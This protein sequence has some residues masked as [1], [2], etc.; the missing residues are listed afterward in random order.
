MRYASNPENL[1]QIAK[2]LGVA[3]IVEGSVQKVGDSVRINVQLVEA[4]TDTHLWAEIYDR[5]LVDVFGIQ[6]EVATAIAQ[7]LQAK[8]TVDEQQQVQARP[9]SNAAA[10]DAYL[11]GL[12]VES[13][14]NF[15][16][17][18]NER[19][20]AFYREATRLDP[21]FVE[22][23]AHQASVQSFLYSNSVGH[24]P[25]TLA[26]LKAAAETTARLRPD[27]GEAWLTEGYYRY[28]GLRD[29][30]GAAKAFE[31]AAAKMP[32]NADVFGVLGSV[33]RRLGQMPAAI[34]HLQRAAELDPGNAGWLGTLG[35][36][37]T[38]LRRYD[39]ARVVIDRALAI[40][41]EDADF[42][43]YKIWSYQAQGNLD[44]A[45][46]L[47]TALPAP[48]DGDDPTL[49]SRLV[50]AWYQRQFDGALSLCDVMLAKAARGAA[51][52]KARLRNHQCVGS[53]LRIKGDPAGARARFQQAAGLVDTLAA[54]GVGDDEDPVY[55]PTLLMSL[56]RTQEA[57]AVLDKQVAAL[58]GDAKEGPSF[59]MLRA[60][61]L[62]RAGKRDE[63]IAILEKSVRMPYGAHA[64]ELRL[65]PSWDMLRGDPRFDALTR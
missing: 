49:S 16:H 40:A 63:A 19:A 51:G 44:A 62:A 55:S 34:K 25:A 29:Y 7:A 5:K 39:E 41:P 48:R 3:N 15:S 52:D 56:G 60:E 23:W 2:E 59:E 21:A 46:K 54:A 58:K 33:E 22:A 38:G 37:L 53:V 43:Q 64:A 30:P 42:M 24:T 4:A 35:E 31:Q 47:L 13:R 12:S 50:Q 6:S 27:S 10:Y 32:N 65:D 28:R 45:G 20:L 57:L 8:L 36:L 11:K 17:A 14:A 26:Q 9:T 61:I 1:Q 18:L